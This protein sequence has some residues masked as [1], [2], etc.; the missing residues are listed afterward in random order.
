M[1]KKYNNKK[2]FTLLEILLVIALIGVLSSIVLVAINPSRQLAEARNTERLDDITKINQAL[3]DYFVTNRAYPTGITS[4]Y[5]DIC[6]PNGG[7][8][9]L[10]LSVLVPSYIP[11]IP[12][13]PNGGNYQ[14]I[15]NPSNG[16]IGLKA[17]NS[18]VG[19]SVAVN[20]ILP[21]ITFAKSAGSIGSDTGWTV[22][23]LANGGS[24]V[25][26]G[27]QNQLTLGAGE[28]NS[29]TLTS[30][31][32]WDI[33]IAKYNTNG[34]LAWAKRAGGAGIDRGIFGTTVLP[35]GSIA[36]HGYFEG[37]AVF[38]QG[39]INQTSLSSSGYDSF[40]AKYNTNGNLAWVKLVGGAPSNFGY[41]IGASA[42]GSITISGVFDGN[43][44]FGVGEPSPITLTSV[45]G[46][47]VY[48]AKYTSSGNI[49]WAKRAGGS[50]SD[51]ARDSIALSD[52][53]SIVTGY[54]STGAI[55]G[56]G[57][58]NQTNL[59]SAGADDIF[60]AKYN[61]DGSLA[62]AKSAGGS[63]S[64][65][66]F[67][68][69]ALS[70]GSSIVTGHFQATAIFG[71]GEVNQ[72]SLVSAGNDDIFIA[73]YNADGILAWAKR[74]GGSSFDRGEGAS[75]LSDGSSIVAGYFQA[76]AIFGQ[77]EVN[78][79]SL[80]SAGSDDIFIAKYNADGSL[81]WAKRAGGSGL[82]EVLG[83]STLSDGS[84]TITGQFSGTAIFGQG[85]PGARTLTSIGGTDLFTARYNK[86]GILSTP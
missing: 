56:Q 55:F 60:I 81:A 50:G 77:G 51:W 32:D 84:L 67:R 41:G 29:I 85:D 19:I 82:D 28:S 57:E 21:T 76:T 78:Q 13:D 44:T 62:W 9:C 45:G 20:P 27:F 4:I 6:P 25:A 46:W 71:Q 79:T 53:S 12:L 80:V 48:V 72:T 63:G 66:G 18:E 16:Q 22:T 36:V 64:D 3:E 49:I 52:G 17:P 54:R 83:A 59:G 23:A 74:A 42:D 11:K 15:I 39:E 61:A 31:G 7:S 69:S 33:F 58:V 73:K 34:S 14:I 5:Q 30:A 43:L 75:I 10:E 47:D 24:I 2:G 86:D 38:G 1:K 8:N 68:I 70:D 35:D 37:T 26:G 40:I 65:I